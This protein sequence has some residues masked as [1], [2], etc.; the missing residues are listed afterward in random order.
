MH[1]YSINTNERSTVLF[2]LAVVSMIISNYLPNLPFLQYEWVSTPKAFAIY[3]IL[4]YLFN[5]WLWIPLSKIKILSTPYLNGDWESKIDSSFNFEKESIVS[6]LEIRQT[7]TKI[8]FDLTTPFSNSE[9][10]DASIDIQPDGRFKISY[11]Y[12]NTPKSKAPKRMT[13]HSGTTHLTVSKN[14]DSFTGFYYTSRDRGNYGDI[15]F[16]RKEKPKVRTFSPAQIL[17]R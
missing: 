5:R 3:G 8:S 16:Q 13:A 11:N 10:C 17:K 9:S 2:F 6:N 7:W 1:N 15:L 12:N 14:K 4:Y